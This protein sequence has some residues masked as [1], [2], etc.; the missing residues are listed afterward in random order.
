M[1]RRKRLL[2]KQHLMQSKIQNQNPVDPSIT[3]IERDGVILF[4]RGTDQLPPET[5]E[6]HPHPKGIE[7]GILLQ[8]LKDYEA[9]NKGGGTL[10][11]FLQEK[12]CRV[13]PGKA[14]DFC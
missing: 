10:Y 13:S 9:A 3:T 11:N 5:H 2:T 14:S 12:F 1:R 6:I 8:M 7:L 4:P